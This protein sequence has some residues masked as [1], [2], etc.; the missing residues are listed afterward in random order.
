MHES[1]FN[2][3]EY[4]RNELDRHLSAA[5]ADGGT[6]TVGDMRA[7]IDAVNGGPRGLDAKV[8]DL[9]IATVAAQSDHRLTDHG[10]TVEPEF[11]RQ[12]SGDTL[13][14]R[15]ELPTKERWDAA[16][17]RAAIIFGITVSKRVNGPEV[18]SLA[19]QA[20]AKANDLI[21]PAED[22]VARCSTA[23]TSWGLDSGNRLDTARAA[24]DLVL[25]LKSASDVEVVEQLASFS[26]PTSAEAVAKSLTTSRTVAAA[27]GRANLGLWS[28]ARPVVEAAATEALTS[29]E[30]VTGFEAAEQSIETQATNYVRSIAPPTGGTSPPP[31]PPTGAESRKVAS[32]E[33]LNDVVD[34]LRE[35]VQSNKT[36]T[37]TWTVEDGA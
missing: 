3:E 11:S 37:V 9:V 33:E 35:H 8:A 29:D 6:S 10:V 7:W 32:E 16:A 4:W 27:L 19:R 21:T 15:E 12:L 26:A 5:T 20:K 25:G 17:E 23:Y 28:T 34:E 31:T 14:V 24:R 13:I 22:L 36:V 1:H 2:L 30:I 18:V